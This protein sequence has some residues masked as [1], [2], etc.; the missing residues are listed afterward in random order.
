MTFLTESTGWM[1]GEIS[2]FSG[3]FTLATSH[4]RTPP[5]EGGVKDT[6]WNYKKIVKN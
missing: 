4:T 5:P 2:K 3:C 6:D 1:K